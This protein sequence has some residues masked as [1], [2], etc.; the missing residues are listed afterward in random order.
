MI[1]MTPYAPLRIAPTAAVVATVAAASLAAAL[2]TGCA[3]HPD[4]DVAA[5][6]ADHAATH[7]EPAIRAGDPPGAAKKAA[8]GPTNRLLVPAAVRANLGVRFQR[9]ELRTVQRTLRLPGRFELRATAT[10]TSHA[11]LAGGVEFAVRELD[12]VKAGQLLAT[13][14]APELRERQHLL[15][16]AE[17][18]IRRAQAELALLN[19]QVGAARHRLRFVQTRVARLGKA[20]ARS[21]SLEGDLLQAK[22]QV[23]VLSIR[24]TAARAEISRERHHREV[25]LREL[26]DVTGLSVSAL[27]APGAK[28]AHGAGGH[29]GRDS[30]HG[31]APRWDT[32]SELQLRAKHDG[33]V[34]KIAMKPGAWADRGAA[35]VDVTD[36]RQLRFV[37]TALQADLGRLREGAAVQVVPANQRPVVWRAEPQPLPALVTGRLRLGVVTDARVRTRTFSAVVAVSKPPTWARAGVSGF[38]E[39]VVAGQASPEVAIPRAAVMRDGLHDVY[40]R[41]D[42]KDPDKVIRTQADLGPDDGRWVAVFSG[43]NAGDEIVVEGAYEL[44]LASSQT[45][46]IKGHFHAD[47]S[48]HAAE[49]E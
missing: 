13:I 12:R 25:Q 23:Q 41:R 15:H 46:A 3:E 14:R 18:A 1:A 31:P 8:A 39:V 49:K 10:R 47:G 48:F 36:D 38:A 35:V 26:T 42:P 44:K 7:V 37:A 2:L 45:D 40:F 20:A 32:L 21:A 17:H 16:K 27:R 4:G 34:T 28:D 5:H 29:D 22:S 11:P 9:A 33:I 24:V 6:P 43:V 30:G 19:A